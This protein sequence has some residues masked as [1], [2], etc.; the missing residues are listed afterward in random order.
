[1]LSLMGLTHGQGSTL[2]VTL[3]AP[4]PAPCLCLPTPI[5][6]P[7]IVSH[8]SESACF[9]SF[10]RER[11]TNGASNV[12]SLRC[13]AC[14]STVASP[15]TPTLPVLCSTVS[16]PAFFSSPSP[17]GSSP[18]TPPRTHTFPDLKN[19]HKPQKA[20]S[21]YTAMA[22][23]VVCLLPSIVN[24]LVKILFTSAS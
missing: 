16:S 21:I 20:P 4:R 12:E 13:A 2:I 9:L 8:C 10:L 19:K 3:C 11:V 6:F 22:L 7:S 1:M 23:M 15:F 24:F 5:F 17:P 18:S 14:Q